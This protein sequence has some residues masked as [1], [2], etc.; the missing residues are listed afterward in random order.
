MTI[1]QR[2][3]GLRKDHNLSQ[4][5]LGEALGVSRQAIYKWESDQ[6]LPEIEK[7]IALS[8][9]FTVSVG[10]LLGV[11]DAPTADVSAETNQTND[12][13]SETQLKMIEE[14]LKR[15]T[16][17][18]EQDFRSAADTGS[19]T[20]YESDGPK[21][22]REDSANG[23]S[24]HQE[25]T[26]TRAKSGPQKPSKKKRRRWPYV[27]AVLAIVYLL[28]RVEQLKNQ[29]NNLQQNLQNSIYNVSRDVNSQLGSLTSQV[30]DILKAQNSLLADY[31]TEIKNAALKENK[32]TFAV[33]ALPKTY[34]E[35]LTATFVADSEGE[36]TETVGTLDPASQKFSGEITCELT[37][38]ITLS[39]VFQSGDKKETQVLQAYNY[40]FSESFY[41]VNADGDC[42]WDTPIN[43]ADMTAT[44]VNRYSLI[45]GY[46]TAK[47]LLMAPVEKVEVGLFRDMTLI[48]WAKPCEQPDNYHGNFDETQFFD[49]GA[50]SFPVKEGELYCVITRVTDTSGR[51]YM[52]ADIPYAYQPKEDPKALSIYY[53]N[54]FYS[55][56]PADYEF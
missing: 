10:W 55:L 8:R 9:L 37:D 39:V 4:E 15:Y 46:D 28:F 45:R 31:S 19:T 56:D 7:L 48:K 42:L 49:F 35:G 3:A 40:L 6:A 14:L 24:W 25:D 12:G 53:D 5:A 27:L 43:T 41:Y 47:E 50:T 52:V 44:L 22:W 21:A 32:I 36:I 26:S 18:P 20:W 38:K 13:F 2:I 1:G 29:Y 34:T 11:E 30:E 51:V 23:P 54:F 33:S 17:T 16:Q